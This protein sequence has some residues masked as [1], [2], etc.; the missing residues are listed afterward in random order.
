MTSS[1]D[2]PATP[3]PRQLPWRDRVRVLLAAGSVLGL[4][5]VG[6]LAAWTDEST[7]SSGTFTAGRLD[8]KVGTTS[9]NVVDANPSAFTTNLVLTNV[10]P[11][12]TDSAEL[13]I[14]NAGTVPF[15][16]TI[17]GTAT[18]N[19]TGANQLGSALQL[20]IYPSSSCSGEVLNSPARL[21]FDQTAGRSLAAGSTTT[22]CFRATLPTTADNALQGSSTVGT[23]TVTATNGS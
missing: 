1:L 2:P 17:A 8:L 23:F 22:L 12:A 15:T 11:G 3:R 7:V 6:T 10:G 4:G 19:G 13:V 14:S 16:Y 5:T 18:N 9:A 21:T 20:Q